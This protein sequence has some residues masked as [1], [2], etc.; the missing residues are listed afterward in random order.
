M[1]QPQRIG[2]T[3]MHLVP[4]LLMAGLFVALVVMMA[5]AFGL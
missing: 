1:R 4:V 5:L 3:V 2:N